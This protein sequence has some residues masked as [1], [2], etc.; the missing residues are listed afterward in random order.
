MKWMK[1]GLILLLISFVLAGTVGLPVFNHFCNTS[2]HSS[3]SV[4]FQ[5]DHCDEEIEVKAC[6][7]EGENHAQKQEE[8][9]CCSDE[10]T[11]YK[12]KFDYYHPVKVEMAITPFI[13]PCFHN[14]F[15][16]DTLLFPKDDA[17][18]NVAFEDPDPPSGREILLQTSILRI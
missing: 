9:D 11:I 15:L 8:K 4:I 3:T 10:T 16:F 12:V 13:V 2:G 14:E 7:S 6:C 17:N 18:N 1:S 5:D